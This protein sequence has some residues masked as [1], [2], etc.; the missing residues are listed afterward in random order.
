MEGFQAVPVQKFD[1]WVP[2]EMRHCHVFCHEAD[3]P[4]SKATEMSDFSAVHHGHSPQS[5]KSGHISVR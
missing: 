4:A 2:G 1:T 3:H 5:T